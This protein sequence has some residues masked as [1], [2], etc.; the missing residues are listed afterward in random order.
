MYKPER[1]PQARESYQSL[2]LRDS[3]FRGREGYGDESRSSYRSAWTTSS[4]NFHSGTERSSVLTRS[5]SVSELSRHRLT[6]M[7]TE[8]GGMSV[9][10]AIGMYARGFHD[11]SEVEDTLSHA[12]EGHAP[13]HLSQAAA[14]I[15]TPESNTKDKV[16]PITEPDDEQ[17]SRESV[18]SAE[19]AE[20]ITAPSSQTFLLPATNHHVRSSTRIIAGD[21]EP[22]SRSQDYMVEDKIPRDR[23]GFKK[24][25]QYVTLEQYDAWDKQYTA[26]VDRRRAKWH[27]LMSSYGLTRENPYRFPLKTDKVK[28]YVRKGIPP[29]WRG[30]AWWWWAG[31]PKR[32]AESRGLYWELVE[33]I[34]QGELSDSDREH[35]ERDLHR[36]FPDNIRFRPEKTAQTDSM[37][38]ANDRDSSLN[39]GVSEPT[40]IL[41]ALRRV[42]QAFAIHN[43]NIGYCQSLNFLAGLLLLFL[44]ENEEHA[45]IM[46]N[47]ITNEYL[48]GTHGKILEAN[49]DIGVL[50]TGIRES[51]PQVWTK[52]N[53]IQDQTSGSAH[54][55]TASARLPTVS[56][57][58]TSW[59]MSLFVSNLPIETVLRVWDVLFFEGSKTLFRIALAIFKVGEPEIRA[60]TDQMEIFQVVQGIPRRLLDANLL[61]ETCYKRRNGFGHLSQET[62]DARRSEGR[63]AHVNDMARING[64]PPPPPPPDEMR[65]PNALQRATSRARIKRSL[66]RRRPRR[67]PTV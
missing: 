62:I 56:L 42:L 38:S 64:L 24:A 66:S 40:P 30:A 48:P 15:P 39:P 29:E 41:N 31:G 49:V 37:Y 46:L 27:L 14:R 59:F 55:T 22:R 16:E 45:F 8:E 3:P 21:T 61:M 67:E 13:R 51:M 47:I 32:L 6:G 57:A 28:R 36:T 2:T 52:I 17:G 19:A 44:D 26:Y 53:D 9:E 33:Q 1:G 11:D 23:Y 25:T 10:D 12:D 54:V 65:R 58:T 63:T 18:V 43:P 60:I 7:T 20:A 4:S 35:I 5:S 50:M 34:N